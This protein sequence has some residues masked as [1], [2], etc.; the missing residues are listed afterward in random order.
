[1]WD[2]WGVSIGSTI[3]ALKMLEALSQTGEHE[4]KDFWL[5]DDLA[6]KRFWGDRKEKSF[7]DYLKKYL[8]YFLHE[9]NQLRS[10]RGIHQECAIIEREKPDL[11][12]SRLDIYITSPEK[13]SKMYNVPFLIEVDSP[14]SYEQMTFQQ[15]Y[16]TTKWLIQS[17]E[18]KFLRGGKAG[19]AVSNQLRDHFVKRGM[20]AEYFSVIPNAAD[21]TKFNPQVS[22]QQVREKLKL[23]NSIVLGFVG[24][25]I[26][27]HGIE[28]L[29][30]IIEKVLPAHPD[31]KFLLVGK[32]GTRSAAIFNFI[33][34]NKLEDR[35]ILPG[36]VP[37][38]E[39]PQYIAAMDILLAPYPEI[40]FFYYSPVKIYEYMACGKPV[41]S[42]RIGQ[43]AELIE[44]QKTGFL[45]APSDVSHI[46]SIIAD[47][48]KQPSVRTQIGMA[49]GA[50]I[51]QH[52]TWQKRGETLSALCKKVVSQ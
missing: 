27:W 51:Q 52:H 2:L 8:G 33:K 21:T 19:F 37:H 28:N 42:S 6:T 9:P 48:I 43:I 25:F 1:M 30:K 22:G 47:L 36:H 4:V 41:I 45:T 3:K 18:M 44:D 20:P 11:V 14:R 24:S 13:L 46:C 7:R 29:M 50:A 34:D 31:A 32:G 10:N 15:Y 40:D 5:R 39:V 49:A 12:I 16:H 17:M 26:T 35:V 38:D 23:N